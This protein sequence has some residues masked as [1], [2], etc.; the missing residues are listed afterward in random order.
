MVAYQVGQQVSY[1]ELGN[2]LGISK[3][4]VERYLDLLQKNY[5]IF[6]LGAYSSNLR[7][8]LSKSSKWYFFDNGIRNALIRNFSSVSLRNDAGQLW[9]NYILSERYKLNSYSGYPAE[10]HFWR[11]Y[12]RQEIDLVEKRNE[13]I[14]AYEIKWGKKK[15]RVPKAWEK[16]YPQSQVHLINRDNYREYLAFKELPSRQRRGKKKDK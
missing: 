11:T 10:L 3:N 5:I 13:Q 2:A 12:D 4:T 14:S 7:K 15:F 6:R 16:A 8:E 9:E 1:N